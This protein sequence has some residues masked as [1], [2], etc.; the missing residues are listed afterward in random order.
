MIPPPRSPN[1]IPCVDNVHGRS[2]F[3][4]VEIVVD[5]DMMTLRSRCRSFT[6]SLHYMVDTL[7]DEE[8]APANSPRVDP[9]G[10][11]PLKRLWPS[12]SIPCQSE[13]S[14]GSF[15]SRTSENILIGQF[16]D[17]DELYSPSGKRHTIKS[18]VVTRQCVHFLYQNTCGFLVSSPCV[19]PTFRHESVHALSCAY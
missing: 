5:D 6:L 4:V 2:L 9:R 1:S 15:G 7:H 13:L 16:L 14:S 19:N 18:C 3:F 8:P 11:V 12:S 17:E 10:H